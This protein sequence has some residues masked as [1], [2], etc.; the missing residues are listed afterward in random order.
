M[1]VCITRPRFRWPMLRLPRQI[2]DTPARTFTACRVL[3]RILFTLARGRH[4]RRTCEMTTP[5]G[6]CIPS[7]MAVRSHRNTISE[8]TRNCTNSRRLKPTFTMLTGRMQLRMQPTPRDLNPGNGGVVVNSG[9]TGNATL[10]T[11]VKTLNQYVLLRRCLRC[12]MD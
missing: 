4:C 5:R 8:P 10:R 2:N 1:T 11:V 9:E 7:V 12:S 3:I 6:A